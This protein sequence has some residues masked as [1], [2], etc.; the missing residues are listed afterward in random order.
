MN[1]EVSSLIAV[2]SHA[3]MLLMFMQMGGEAL[4]GNAANS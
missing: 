3:C 4:P 1:G 2:G